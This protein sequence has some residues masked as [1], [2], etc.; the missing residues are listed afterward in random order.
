MFSVSLLMMRPFFCRFF[1]PHRRLGKNVV[2][3]PHLAGE[4]FHMQ[5]E[6]FIIA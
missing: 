4:D 5:K 1:F 2:N 6:K 3:L